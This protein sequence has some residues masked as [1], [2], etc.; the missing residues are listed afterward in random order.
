[1]KYIV[2]DWASNV[3]QHNGK[4]NFSAYGA[5]NG[6]PML[7]DSFDDA[8]AYLCEKHPNPECPF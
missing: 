5:N 4:F 3:L 8:W 7:F 2:K 1:M 6:V